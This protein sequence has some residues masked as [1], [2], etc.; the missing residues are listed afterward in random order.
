MSL[1]I[2]VEPMWFQWI[3]VK[4]SYYIFRKQSWLASEL[5]LC[6]GNVC[7]ISS[8]EFSCSV[9]LPPLTLV[10]LVVCHTTATGYLTHK[11]KEFRNAHPRKYQNHNF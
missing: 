2:L 10:Y 7:Q 11:S 1:T 3:D 9:I 5:R 4:Q 6:T 8:F